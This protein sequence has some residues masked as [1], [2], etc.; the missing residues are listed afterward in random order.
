MPVFVTKSEER[1]KPVVL[2][3]NA[4][5]NFLT[6]A[7]RA[8][9]WT[10]WKKGSDGDGDRDNGGG[11]G[12]NDLLD[13]SRPARRRIEKR[14]R[15]INGQLKQAADLL[16]ERQRLYGE[17]Q[18]INEVKEK[19]KAH[20]E[21]VAL[22]VTDLETDGGAKNP[23]QVKMTG[24]QKKKKK[25]NEINEGMKPQDRIKSNTTNTTTKSDIGDTPMA[26]EYIQAI[27]GPITGDIDELKALLGEAEFA[28]F[29]TEKAEK[30]DDVVKYV[31]AEEERFDSLDVAELGESQFKAIFGPLKNAEKMDSMMS[32]PLPVGVERTDWDGN[33]VMTE[34]FNQQLDA[35]IWA[36]KSAI[37]ASIDLKNDV[38]TVKKDAKAAILGFASWVDT[39]L[40]TFEGS[41]PMVNAVKSDTKPKLSD[42][43]RRFLGMSEVI[44]DK[45]ISSRDANSVNKGDTEMT[46]EEIRV[47]IREENAGLAEA[48]AEKTAQ[49]T[50]RVMVEK[51]DADQKAKA[52][53]E[54]QKRLDAEKADRE[55]KVDE[56]CETVKKLAEKA[57]KTDTETSDVAKE[58]ENVKAE[59]AE[60]ETKRTELAE[61]MD[62]LM[63]SPGAPSG[64]ETERGKGNGNKTEAKKFDP[65]K[66][67]AAFDDMLV[68]QA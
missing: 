25:D 19:N 7:G 61:K 18:R 53:S 11:V 51:A 46:P 62:R 27:L 9:N 63:R 4:V 44:N 36:L 37:C 54:E 64:G 35:K 42:R 13:G 14:I 26:G 5:A 68:A 40:D 67:Y 30:H 65:E 33:R 34:P 21:E 1:I 8:A 52:E 59:L 31:Q 6:L 17:L 60:A 58:I 28:K 2:L 45:T 22:S 24:T 66:P 23:A 56:M 48:V 55:K 47:L 50:V 12:A 16:H 39:A 41:L 43:F 57:E 3:K 49:E 38:A 15:T 10:P 20:K 32:M 29:I